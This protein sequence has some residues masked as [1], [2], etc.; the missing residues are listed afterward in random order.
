M[1]KC[2]VK[3]GA[4]RIVIDPQSN[5]PFQALAPAS[6]ADC[7][8]L[9]WQFRREHEVDVVRYSQRAPYPLPGQLFYVPLLQA[10][11]YRLQR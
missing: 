1:R 2:R 7:L 4:A 11:L 8:Y 10:R 5:G 9:E 3:C 6:I